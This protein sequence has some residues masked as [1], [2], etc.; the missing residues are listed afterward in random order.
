MLK[1]RKKLRRGK[2]EMEDKTLHSHEI[3]VSLTTLLT[4]GLDLRPLLRE[5]E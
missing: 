3:S 1:E 4:G 5:T 2:K